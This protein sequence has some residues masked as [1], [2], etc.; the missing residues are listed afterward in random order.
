MVTGNAKFSHCGVVV[1]DYVVEA[2]LWFG[3]VATPVKEWA[4]RHPYYES[5]RIACPDVQAAEAF[6]WSQIGKPYDYL[7][8]LG[9]PLRSDWQNPN[10]WYCSELVEAALLA[11]GRQR[12]RDS[13]AG[14]S[15]QES[16][17]VL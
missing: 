2:R 15:P 12:W 17:D 14:I 16:W 3:V 7:G 10:K 5:L 13:K 8:A 9:M 11:G 4:A 6:A 1:G